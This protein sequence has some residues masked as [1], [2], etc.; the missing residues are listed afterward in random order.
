MNTLVIARS[1]VGA[2]ELFAPDRLLRAVAGQ[3]TDSRARQVTRVLG[4]R[5]ILQAAV[6]AVQP[7]RRVL[8]GGATVDALHAASMVGLGVLNVRRRREA[9]TSAAVAGLF[10][11]WQLVMSSRSRYPKVL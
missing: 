3:D 8:V 11:M 4:T 7:S 2:A 5:E 6:T 1:I 9:L 10:T